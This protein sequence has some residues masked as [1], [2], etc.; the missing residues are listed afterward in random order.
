MAVMETSVHRDHG[1]DYLMEGTDHQT[2]SSTDGPHDLPAVL[3]L[4]TH[5]LYNI[6]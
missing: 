3:D 5:L 1:L 6:R 2:K 4:G